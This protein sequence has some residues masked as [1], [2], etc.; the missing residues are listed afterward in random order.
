MQPNSPRAAGVGLAVHPNVLERRRNPGLGIGGGEP[1]ETIWIL[2]QSSAFK[3]QRRVHFKILL[4]LRFYFCLGM[5][6]YGGWGIVE[7]EC[8]GGRGITDGG[9]VDNGFLSWQVEFS[10]RS[11]DWT[12]NGV[13]SRE[14][15]ESRSETGG[16]LSAMVFVAVISSVIAGSLQ[17]D[18][19][20]MMASTPVV[21]ETEWIKKK[22]LS[23][24]SMFALIHA[25]SHL[26]AER[27]RLNQASLTAMESALGNGFAGGGYRTGSL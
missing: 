11:A 20:Q 4:L 5:E 2:Q 3:S 18:E 21:L 1:Q 27:G 6:T 23:G 7:G 26:G 17:K 9:A 12:V 15:A 16:L 10:A 24:R 19:D 25:I 8:S 13:S 14:G 22:H